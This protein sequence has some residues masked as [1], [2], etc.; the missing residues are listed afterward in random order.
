MTQAETYKAGREAYKSGQHS[1]GANADMVVRQVVMNIVSRI[2]F[3]AGERPLTMKQ[4]KEQSKAKRKKA[5]QA[6]GSKKR[7]QI[8]K[9]GPQQEPSACPACGLLTEPPHSRRNSKL[10]GKY[11]PRRAK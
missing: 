1:D 9:E 8:R 6:R 5:V 2:S 10:C 4:R 11:V 3:A 7:P